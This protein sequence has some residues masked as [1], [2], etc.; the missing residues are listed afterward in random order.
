MNLAEPVIPTCQTLPPD[1]L[2]PGYVS[3]DW[4]DQVHTAASHTGHGFVGAGVI[5][6]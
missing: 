2:V 4:I 6:Y 3:G 1:E 5:G